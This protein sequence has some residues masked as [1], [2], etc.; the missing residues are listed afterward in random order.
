MAFADM[1]DRALFDF[2]C[3][4]LPLCDCLCCFTFFET[5]AELPSWIRFSLG[6]TESSRRY[7]S[8]EALR[9]LRKLIL[10]IEPRCPLGSPYMRLGTVSDGS[11][12]TSEPQDHHG[13]SCPLGD[14]L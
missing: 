8:G 5:E 11:V 3:L 13:L 7:G 1:L 14:N 12:N 2:H 4:T 6:C 10:G 9:Q